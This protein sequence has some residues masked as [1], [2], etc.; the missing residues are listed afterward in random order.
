MNSEW[1]LPPVHK[2][3]VFGPDISMNNTECA[4]MLQGCIHLPND[5]FNLWNE[6]TF[7]SALYIIT[8]VLIQ[9]LKT[10]ADVILI[11]EAAVPL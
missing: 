7:S 6:E 11:C 8:Q 3:D 10:D 9:Q 4:Q 1:L 2:H 5:Y